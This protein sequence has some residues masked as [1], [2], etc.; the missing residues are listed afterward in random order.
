[1]T[2][3][4]FIPGA[5]HGSWCWSEVVP[6]LERAGHR[7]L[8]PDLLEASGGAAALPEQPLPT[9]ADR[10]AA[11]V[12]PEPDPVV[13]V[14]HSRGGLVISEVAE[15]VPEKVGLLVYLTAFLLR[16]GQTLQ[17]VAQ[18]ADNAATFAEALSFNDGLI[19]LSDDGLQRFLYNQ[20]PKHLVQEARRRLVSE[21]ASTFVTPIHVIDERFGTVPRAYIECTNDRAIPLATQRLM[22]AAM[23]C[24]VTKRLESIIRRSSP[25]RSSWSRRSKAAFASMLHARMPS[26]SCRVLGWRG[27]DCGAE[28]RTAGEGR[29]GSS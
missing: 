12:Q 20:V 21:P 22:Q 8:T 7:V 26:R 19:T 5:G 23:P 28:L 6:L 18:Q 1:M 25:C 27:R 3:Y 24:A 10:I 17:E 11:I 4:V 13:L 15:R 16:D 14:G 2:T 29:N 9:W